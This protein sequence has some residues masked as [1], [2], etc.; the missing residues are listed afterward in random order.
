LLVLQNHLVPNHDQ[1][2]GFISKNEVDGKNT[3]EYTAREIQVD[4]YERGYL[5]LLSQLTTVGNISRRE[6]KEQLDRMPKDTYRIVVIEHPITHKIVAAAT[7][8]VEKKFVHQCG[9][10]GHIEDVV[11]DENIRGK[12]LGIKVI[13]ACKQF[14]EQ[15]G[16]YK[17]ILDCSEK[18]VPF[19]ER[20]GFKKKELQM[21]F[22]HPEKK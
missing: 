12:Y 19:Y 4:D 1:I 7:V 13:E 21:R 3:D 15:Q 18:N 14:A 6:F 10:V 16:C 17:T 11:V 9:S 8:F 22:D 2:V 5:S 20:C